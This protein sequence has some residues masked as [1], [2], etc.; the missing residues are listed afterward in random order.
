MK[1]LMRPSDAWRAHL[2]CLLP[3]GERVQIVR[4]LNA[5]DAMDRLGKLLGDEIERHTTTDGR[6]D[7]KAVAFEML[8]EIV[9]CQRTIAALRAPAAIPITDAMIDKAA[10]VIDEQLT[11]LA[12]VGRGTVNMK[13]AAVAVYC[14]MTGRPA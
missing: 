3:R 4:V 5:V 11:R 9:R 14:A 1:C 2:G 10:D 8:V 13:D 7:L 12:H 6:V